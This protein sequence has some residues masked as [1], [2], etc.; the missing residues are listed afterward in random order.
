[1]KT[2]LWGLAGFLLS[3]VLSIGILT[4]CTP[5]TEQEETEEIPSSIVITDFENRVI[6][7]EKIPEK[8]VSLSPSNTE[9]LFSLG[10]GDKIVGVSDYCDYPAA[11]LDKP[12]IGGFA[13]SDVERIVAAQPDVIFASNIQVSEILPSLEALGQTVIVIDPRTISQVLDSVHL[14]G[15]ATGTGQRAAEI[16]EGMSARIKAITDKTAKLT[17]EE[18]LSVFYVMWHE[19]L[20]TVGSGTL[21][22]EMI[23]RSGGI[24]PFN[25][26]AGYPMISIETLVESNPQ[27]II[28]GTGMG[29]GADAPFTFAQTEELL[30][31]CDARVNNRIYEVNTDLT[32]RASERLIDGF[33]AI[34]K[35]IHPELFK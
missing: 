9:I 24:N 35:M 16:V 1:M 23:T 28:A 7:L 31:G 2:R 21:I 29:E 34:A 26:E 12:K 25:T 30:A 19:P 4:G 33:E 10:L 13:N 20:M 17:E 3:I 22:D 15:T 14:I 18:K 32:G 8:I 27:V 6:T 11:A 5:S